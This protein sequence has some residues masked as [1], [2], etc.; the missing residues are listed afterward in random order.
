MGELGRALKVSMTVE[1]EAVE[2]LCV[3]SQGGALGIKEVESVFME[4]GEDVVLATRRNR[5]IA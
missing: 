3:G 2:D 5:H 1:F 4:D